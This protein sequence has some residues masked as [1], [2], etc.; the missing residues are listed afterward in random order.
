MGL[1]VLLLVLGSHHGGLRA[2]GVAQPSVAAGA[3]CTG[4]TPVLH[5]RRVVTR[6]TRVLSDTVVDLPDS[7]PNAWR[8]EQVALRYEIDVSRCAGSPGV[9]LSL[10]R[11]GAPF[12][13]H[14]LGKPIGSLL[15]QHWYEP[16]LH[17]AAARGRGDLIFNGRIPNLL[18]LPPD[19]HTVEIRLLTLPYI[20]L[21]LAAMTLG[22]TNAL[23]PTALANLDR[24]VGYTDAAAGV[25]LVL[26]LMA[27]VLWLQRRHDL[28]FLWMTLACLSWSVRALAFYD[29]NV[30]VSPIWFE[31]FNPFNILLTAV[32]LFAATLTTIAQRSPTSAA[33]TYRDWRRRPRWILMFAIVSSSLALAL[34]VL[35]ESGA[36]LAR[37]YAQAWALGLSLATI[38]WIWSERIWLSPLH[39]YATIAA[40]AGLIAC[41]AHDMALVTGT[42]ASTRPSYLFWGFTVVLVVYAL[43]SG[44]YIISTLNRA[45]NSNLELEQRIA[46]KSSE[47]EESYQQLRKTEMA[48]ALSSARLQERERLLRDMHDGL[49]AQLMTA[50]RGVER[51]ALSREQIA[52][53]LQDGMDELRMLMD[54]A[55]IGSDVTLALAAW[56]NRWDNRLGAAGVQLHWHMDDSIDGLQLDSDVLLQIMRILQEAATNVVKHAHA[57]NL[58]VQA[59]QLTR[60]AQSWLVIDARDDGRGLPQ[61]DTL[62]SQRGLRNMGHRASQIGAQLDIASY[63]DA[64]EGCRVLLELR[65][66]PPPDRPERRSHA[67]TTPTGPGVIS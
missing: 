9:A 56:R 32:A 12:V 54:S 45:E 44:D 8:N 28:G 25:M 63:G 13:A 48:R 1:A 31:Q 55:D 17:D 23:L 38:W 6:G 20:P 51:S 24:V 37:G 2:Q 22:P 26:A 14:A 4:A 58:H 60:N 19:A 53:S 64:P 15:T 65:I 59:R 50:L 29:R 47:L 52:Q 35:F 61:Q 57:R 30:Y 40:Y 62:R 11:V 27:G 67:R 18:A 33:P 49:G 10:Y 5:A 21:G 43:I 42:I 39:R 34:S 16:S 7:L 3:A 36:M 66:D 41:A 46:G